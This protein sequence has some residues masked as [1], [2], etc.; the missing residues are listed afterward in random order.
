MA[1]L[2]RVRGIMGAKA[3]PIARLGS[4]HPTADEKLRS[5]ESAGLTSFGCVGLRLGEGVGAELR[6]ERS[7]GSGEG[8]G[9]LSRCPGL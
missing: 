9:L 7:S 3:S 8:N 1:T 6:R 2:E 4:R 5:F